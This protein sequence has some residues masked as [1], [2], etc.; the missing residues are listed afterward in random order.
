MPA[1]IATAVA[2][3]LM[4]VCGENDVAALYVEIPGFG[5]GKRPGFHLQAAGCDGAR[6]TDAGDP[7]GLFRHAREQRIRKGLTRAPTRTF[8]GVRGG[9]LA[10]IGATTDGAGRSGAVHSPIVS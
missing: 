8:V 3:A 6:R 5:P 10:R 2:A 4:V 9:K 7:A 1:A